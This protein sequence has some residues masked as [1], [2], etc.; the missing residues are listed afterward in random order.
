M[1]TGRRVTDSVEMDSA[2]LILTISKVKKEDG[3]NYTC[4][5]DSGGQASQVCHVI[6]SRRRLFFSE[7]CSL[8]ES[9]IHS[10]ILLKGNIG[11]KL[12]S[13]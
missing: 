5:P 4:A 2:I 10:N 12:K 11:G 13:M 7:N 3:G 1:N 9:L 8:S 6:A